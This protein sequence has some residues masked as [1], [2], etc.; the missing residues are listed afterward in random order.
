MFQVKICGITRVDD[1]RAAVD[2]GADCVGLNFFPGSKRCLNEGRAAEIVNALPPQVLPVGL[3]VNAGPDEVCRLFDKLHF[4][5]IQLHGDEPPEY[6]L[7]LGARPVMRAFHMQA[8]GWAPVIDY[9]DRCRRL[10]CLPR[11]AL[12]DAFQPGQYGGTGQTADWRLLSDWRRRLPDVPLVLAGGLTADNVAEAIGIV[13]PAAVDT[14]SGV[15]SEPGI[16]DRRKVQ[17]FVR[18]ARRALSEASNPGLPS[19]GFPSILM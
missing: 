17:S 15:E 13:R 18:A 1:A 14:A 4:G 7:R 19:S 10:G 12:V 3:F 5:L 2:A 9:L 16:K 11:M 8:D 6:L